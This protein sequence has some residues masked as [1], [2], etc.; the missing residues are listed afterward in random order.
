MS[1]YYLSFMGL[2]SCHIW[3]CKYCLRYWEFHWDISHMMM[4]LIIVKLK[5]RLHDILSVA[6][7]LYQLLTY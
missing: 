2:K 5:Q 6:M 4:V 7:F 1:T 3:K